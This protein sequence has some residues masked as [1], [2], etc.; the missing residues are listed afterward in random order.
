M[1]IATTYNK[2]N[3]LEKP[4][5]GKKKFKL[6]RGFKIGIIITIL[7]SSFIVFS[8]F[9]EIAIPYDPIRMYVE[10][11]Q[12]VAIEKEDKVDVKM[13]DDAVSSGD[14]PKDF[15]DTITL[16][17]IGHNG[18]NGVIIDDVSKIVKRNGKSIRVVYI[19][20]KKLLFT[21]LFID[22]D[23]QGY[24]DSG[25]GIRYTGIEKNEKYQSFPTEVYYLKNSDVSKFEKLS[26]SKFDALREH[27]DLIWSGQTDIPV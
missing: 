27:C 2:N 9:Y 1:E 12:F 13:L 10:P 25:Y 4:N 7:L 22:S 16:L 23:L 5:D 24:R 19:S 15:S 21:S 17:K 26:G 18:M 11:V 3:V 6:T 8:F 20:G 14:V